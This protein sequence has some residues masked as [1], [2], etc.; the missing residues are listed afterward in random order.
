MC[1]RCAERQIYSQSSRK[2]PRKYRPISLLSQTRKGFES[3]VNKVLKKD[4][5]SHEFQ[6]GF[7]KGKTTGTAI[8]RETELQRNGH[9]SSAV[10]DLKAA[11]DTV[12]RKYLQH[13]M[14]KKLTKNVSTM[15]E[16]FLAPF[17][18]I[19]S[20]IFQKTGSLWIEEYRKV[21]L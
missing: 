13:R 3:A 7:Q 10:L 17:R 12:P 15:C 6:L 14:R 4:Y 2:N 9:R 16:A 18:Y 20:E 5:S 1:Q 21:H 19:L 11:Y 8:L